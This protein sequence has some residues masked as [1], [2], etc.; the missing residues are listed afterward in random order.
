[1]LVGLAV[2]SAGAGC[3][4]ITTTRP[5]LP[6]GHT[7]VRDQLVI[8]SDFPLAA[9]HRL[10]EELAAR[11]IDLADRLAIPLSD[12]PIHVYLFDSADPFNA[13]IRL[14]HPDFPPRRAYFLET[15]T[16]LEVYAQWDDRVAED[17]RHEVT[18]GYLHSVIPNL[19]LWLDE[20][21]A[22][23]SEVP[24]GSRGLNQP[25]LV[26]LAGR[27]Q[28]G[29]WR[30]D[31]ER[32]ET[33]QRPFDMTQ[34]DYAEAW[35]WVHF[36][37][38][39]GPRCHALLRHYLVDL[40]RHGSAEPMSRRLHAALGEPE[41]RLIEHIRAVATAEGVWQGGHRR[42][43]AQGTRAAA[44]PRIGP[45]NRPTTGPNCASVL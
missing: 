9:S 45:Q 25:H 19:P 31:L 41:P 1:L 12:E 17:L 40:R 13:F 42:P 15:D 30:A 16:R 36:L 34:L 7:V 10:L 27:V 2:L 4:R 29:Q 39:S 21:L 43:G 38:E 35:A 44:D 32:L 28:L 18:H 5:T 26:A 8:H 24:R 11:R 22:E 6:A 37:L 14:H 23:Y 3:A 33:F 20:G